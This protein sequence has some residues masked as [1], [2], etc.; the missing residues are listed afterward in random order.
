MQYDPKL[1]MAMNEIR[2]ILAK[3][4]IAGLVVLHNPPGHTEYML[5]LSP[6]WS[7]AKIEGEA[8]RVRAR[9]QEDFNGDRKAWTKKV[10][11][12][13]GMLNGI[14]TVGGQMILSMATL[15]DTVDKVVD[16]T[17]WDKGHTSE[18]TQNN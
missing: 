12:T 17:H 9:I 3:H 13:L 15:S 4:D 11:E 14:T 1:K 10:T 2:G 18:T 7:C 8:V 6:S 5:Q 16:A